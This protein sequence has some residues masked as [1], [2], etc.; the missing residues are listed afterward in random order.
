MRSIRSVRRLWANAPRHLKAHFSRSLM[1]RLLVLSLT[2]AAAMTITAALVV[3]LLNQ[4]RLERFGIDVARTFEA[5]YAEVLRTQTTQLIHALESV[6]DTLDQDRAI[7]T[8]NIT[9][10]RS[11]WDSKAGALSITVHDA[12]GREI[13]TVLATDTGLT[14]GSA[15]PTL[16]QSL[17]RSGSA[18]GLMRDPAL[19]SVGAPL[20]IVAGIHAGTDRYLFG[21]LN[22]RVVAQKVESVYAGRVIILG[23]DGS[24]LWSGTNDLTPALARRLAE[25]AA[26]Q[27]FTEGGVIYE[28]IRAPLHDLSGRRVGS[29]SV[30]RTDDG[31]IAAEN[32]LDTLIIVVTLLGFILFAAALRVGMR[33]ELLPLREVDRLVKALA[34]SDFHAPALPGARRD[35]LGRINRS[36]GA[37]RIA[38]IERD[39]TSFATMVNHSQERLLIE[40]ELRQFSAMLPPQERE[41]I[42]RM[43]AEV[44]VHPQPDVLRTDRIDDSP[45]TVAFRFMSDRVRAQQERLSN[46]LA[47]RTAD[48]ETVR[49]AL[50]ERSDLFRLREELSVARALQLSMQPDPG[51]LGSVRE[52]VEVQAV[53]RPAKEVG[54]DSYDFQL[55]DSGRRL[56][57]LI[58]DSSGK[59]VPAAMFVLTSKL[60]ASGASEVFGRLDAGLKAANAALSRSNEAM[61]FTTLFIG[62]LDLESGELRYSN[63]GHNPPLLCRASG[64]LTPLNQAR[65]LVLGAFDDVQYEEV[66]IQLQPGDSLILYT[67]GITEAHDGQ[68]A[69]FG[70]ERLERACLTARD[71]A[72]DQVI[73]RVLA[74]VD[75]FCGDA[76]QYD[77]ITLMVLRYHGAREGSTPGTAVANAAA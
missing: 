29:I 51:S 48:L 72:P 23:G 58:C 40:R 15:F 76:P 55:L 32:L 47:E 8:R 50:E 31:D 64:D 5:G 28:A 52:L 71:L 34:A 69:M 45:L 11:H 10:L 46:L 57:F 21:A 62:M 44:G 13:K 3:R 16:L 38:A 59:G 2:T 67:D 25:G 70:D 35:E 63:A 53:M 77:D 27:V 60:L 19:Q 17:S 33:R 75:L 39:R 43:L 7:D 1:L 12:T 54:G 66:C 65:G 18:A 6:R 41:E 36:I 42:L 61:S 4:A 74:E 49:R 68:Q 24:T 14:A 22:F 20:A 26:Y 56:M 9:A 37:L 30:L 73:Q